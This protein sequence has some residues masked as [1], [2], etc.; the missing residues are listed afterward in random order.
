MDDIHV[1]SFVL[2]F[3]KHGYRLRN[4]NMHVTERCIYHTLCWVILLN[5]YTGSELTSK[6]SIQGKPVP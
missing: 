6:G 3:R 5:Y 1:Q 2:C 4:V